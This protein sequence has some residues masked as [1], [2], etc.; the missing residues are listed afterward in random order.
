MLIGQYEAKI[1]AKGRAAFPKKL[2]EILGEKLIITLGYENS[3]IIV[4]ETGWK[5]LLEGTEGKPFIQ[6]EARETQRFLLGG[7]NNIELDSKGRFVIPNYLRSFGKIKGEVVFIGMYRY[8]E[9]WD[10]ARWE[11]YRLNLEENIDRI[12]KRL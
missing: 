9:M 6:R 1:D 3:L 4:S 7:A 2:R 11:E 10:K 8:V 5:A 12:S